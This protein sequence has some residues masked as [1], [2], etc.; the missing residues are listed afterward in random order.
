[1][2]S[3]NGWPRR[4]DDPITVEGRA[5]RTLRDAASISAISMRMLAPFRR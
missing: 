3:G 1:V 5:L 4:F 2:T